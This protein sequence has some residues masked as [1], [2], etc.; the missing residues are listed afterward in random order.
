MSLKSRRGLWGPLR[1]AYVYSV[2]P[3]RIKTAIMNSLG[4]GEIA[5]LNRGMAEIPSLN[6]SRKSRILRDFIRTLKEAE[7]RKRLSVERGLTASLVVTAALVLFSLLWGL[8]RFG[9]VGRGLEFTES[10]ILHGG[11]HWM[12][13][14]LLWGYLASRSTR[15]AGGLSGMFFPIR[16]NVVPDLFIAAAGGFT[17]ALLLAGFPGAG[18]AGME[19]PVR[20]FYILAAVTAGPLLE[21]LFFRYHLF[22]VYGERYGYGVCGLV[23]SVLFALVHVPGSFLLFGAYFG[24]GVLLCVLIHIRK[25]TAVPFIAHALANVLLLMI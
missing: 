13:L 2:M 11:L 8:S 21:E 5:R 19:P 15:S 6:T 17:V 20:I 22:L 3:S 18:P 23:S 12:L 24:A 1:A 7:R 16:R 4:T 25:N 10:L 9:T 14:P